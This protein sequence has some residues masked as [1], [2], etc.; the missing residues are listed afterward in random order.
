[1]KV[2]TLL[3]QEASSLASMGRLCEK[4][5]QRLILRD[6]T[7]PKTSPGYQEVAA[8]PHI[9][10]TCREQ[11]VFHL[12]PAARREVAAVCGFPT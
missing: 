8:G 12:L 11:V 5:K 4:T 1:M 7:E 9:A 6:Y 2:P 3:V 10:A